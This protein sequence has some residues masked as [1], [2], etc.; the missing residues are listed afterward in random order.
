MKKTIKTYS[1]EETIELAAALA[2]KLSKGDLIALVGDLGAGKTQ[3]AKGI[4][5]GLNVDEYQYVNSASFVVLKEY[6]GTK[7][8]YHFDIY[9]L[10]EKDFCDTID[11][12]KY[13]YSDGISVVEW[14]DKIRD[15]LPEEYL[16]IDIK[17]GEGDERLFLF[18]PFG[19]RYKELV[20]EVISDK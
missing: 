13:F 15:I 8:L 7:D 14:A 16:E 20:D 19:A 17:Y 1:P 2:E 3:F 6:S 12:E 9:R 18:K 4:A 5:K 11:Y 10:E